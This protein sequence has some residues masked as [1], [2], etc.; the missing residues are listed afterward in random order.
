MKK[1]MWIEKQTKVKNFIISFARIVVILI[2][3]AVLFPIFELIFMDA[4]VSLAKFFESSRFEG[5]NVTIRLFITSIIPFLICI[6]LSI[7]L[8]LQLLGGNIKIA[9][10]AGAV[11]GLLHFIVA[12]MSSVTKSVDVFIKMGILQFLLIP[13]AALAGA[14]SY[15]I[16]SKLKAMHQNK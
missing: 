4:E 10:F 5:W 3:I 9:I 2:L 11:A 7:L 12:G 1:Y 15:F 6:F 14:F 8:I 16:I 13:L